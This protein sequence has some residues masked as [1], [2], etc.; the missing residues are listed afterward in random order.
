MNEKWRVISCSSTTS[1]GKKRPTYTLE[2]IDTGRQI[3]V[4]PRA[5]FDIE[6]GITT[7]DNVL[8]FRYWGR[9]EWMSY[10]TTEKAKMK[11]EAKNKKEK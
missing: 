5:I 10:I 3:E 11:R 2:N 7:V 8:A 4:S 1:D 9:K 6:A